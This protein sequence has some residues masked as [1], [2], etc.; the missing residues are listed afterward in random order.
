VIKVI[1]SIKQLAGIGDK[2]AM[3]IIEHFGSEQLAIDAMNDFQIG[4]IIKLP[5]SQQ[6][7]VDIIRDIHR[8]KYGYSHSTILKTAE[9]KEYYTKIMSIFRQYASTDYARYAI[10][11][12]CPVKDQKEVLR[13]QKIVEDSLE[14]IDSLPIASIKK[15]K[16]AIKTIESDLGSSGIRGNQVCIGTEDEE[17]YARLKKTVPSSVIVQF[18]QTESDVARLSEYDSP[19]YLDSEDSK[20]AMYADQIERLE[21]LPK[22]TSIERACPEIVLDFV[23][24]NKGRIKAA[25]QVDEILCERSIFTKD[26]ADAIRS[27]AKRS[28]MLTENGIDPK[29][30]E[31]FRSLHDAIRNLNDRSLKE[32]ADI[33]S[34]I[35]DVVANTSMAGDELYAAL[36]SGEPKIPERVLQETINII[37]KHETELAKEFGMAENDFA[38]LFTRDGISPKV[39]A[40]KKDILFTRWR[41]EMNTIRYRLERTIAEDIDNPIGLCEQMFSA[42]LELDVT[43]TIGSFTKM[44]GLKKPRL[45][46][47]NG[48][49]ISGGRNIFLVKEHGAENVQPVDYGLDA[50]CRASVVTGANSGG[51]TTLLE[52]V[53]QAHIMASMGLYIGATDAELPLLDIL[54]VFGKNRGGTSAG[55]FETLLRSFAEIDISDGR[56]KMVL[57]DEIE[58]VTEP[59]AAAKI[60]AAIIRHLLKDKDSLVTVVTHLGKEIDK[61]IDEGI[62]IDGIEAKGLDEDFNIIVDRNPKLGYIATSTPELIIRRL[63]KKT[64]GELYD[65]ICESMR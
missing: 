23:V 41:D 50:A 36:S 10:S 11:V 20:F 22:D 46:E 8:R 43:L 56:R 30:D 12:F 45:H 24:K 59:G 21:Y 25:V 16:D 48:Y 57:A 44:L 61:E 2:G 39:S 29:T 62:R 15:I 49:L 13:R 51:K 58:A 3:R 60:V 42:L 37:K 17:I 55:A 26:I 47:K 65:A 18:I 64:G 9:A 31:K 4:D 63:A 7:R 35:K 1:D 14:L 40:E 54:Y 38:G 6:A 52:M 27:L 34:Q 32:L 5:I 19:R 33:H 28:E 53:A